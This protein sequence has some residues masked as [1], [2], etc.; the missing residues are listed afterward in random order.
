[1]DAEVETL[2]GAAQGARSALRETRRSGY[3]ERDWGTRA[4]RIALAIP[5]LRKG[6][7]F[8]GFP[9]P[10]RTAETAPAAVVRGA[11]RPCRRARSAD[12]PV[13]AMG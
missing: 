5:K 6:S 2:A 7:G 4:G 11:L 8:P 3:R 10:R 9:E 13:K 12:D 1:M